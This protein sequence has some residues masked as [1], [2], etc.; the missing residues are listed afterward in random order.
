MVQLAALLREL[1]GSGPLQLLLRRYRLGKD[2]VLLMLELLKRRL[3]NDDPAVKGRE[4]LAILSDTS[5]GLLEGVRLLTTGTNLQAAREAALA[6]VCH[7]LLNTSEFL[8]IP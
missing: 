8:C 5:F 3:T 2:H 6:R 1:G 4:L 7:T